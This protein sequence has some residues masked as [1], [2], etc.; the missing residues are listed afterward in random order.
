M[1]IKKKMASAVVMME[2]GA[3]LN[4]TTFFG[5]SYLAKYLSGNDSKE[6]LYEKERH[7]KA[8]EKYQKDYAAYEEK[9]KKFL[10]WKDENR[11][12]NAIASRNFA[13]T[14]EVLKYYNKMH[15][16]EHL[17]SELPQFGDYYKPSKGQMMGEMVY[18]GG[19]MMALGYLASHWF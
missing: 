15:E 12:S 16:D 13:N 11:S 19:G 1:K 18:V 2:G 10:Y 7:D 5:G 17:A 8:L 14:D 9:R 6:I 4:A 3:V